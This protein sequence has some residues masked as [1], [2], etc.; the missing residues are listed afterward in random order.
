MLGD[1]LDF[2]GGLLGQK[3]QR[4][5][6]AEARRQFDLQMNQSVQRR[7]KDAQAAGIHPLFAMGANVGASPTFH[8]PS[9]SAMGDALSRIGSRLANAKI[10]RES[11]GAARDE[12]EAALL[13]SER[14]RLEQQFASRGHDGASVKTYPYGTEKGPEIVFGPAMYEPP[15][16]PT[17]KRPGVQSGTI[18]AMVDV[19]GTDGRSHT[20]PNPDFFDDIG[21][22]GFMEFVR[23]SSVAHVVRQMEGIRDTFRGKLQGIEARKLERELASL[24]RQRALEQ[25]YGRKAPD[26]EAQAQRAFKYVRDLYNKYVR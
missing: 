6:R 23:K 26:Y 17:S 1:L 3:E 24:K 4:K 21:S 8:A 22:P 12:A 20:V 18:P 10:A 25:K 15:R 5:S 2:A 14:K 19:M 9:G 7:V 11:A 13:D 16:L